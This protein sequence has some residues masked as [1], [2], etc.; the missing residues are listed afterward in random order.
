[1]KLK[2]KK[3]HKNITKANKKITYFVYVYIYIHT[4]YIIY[5]Y[6]YTQN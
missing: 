3:N 1:M 2:W 4:I 5:I 6:I